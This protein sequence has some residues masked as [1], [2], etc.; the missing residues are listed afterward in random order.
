LEVINLENL[1]RKALL[2]RVGADTKSAGYIGDVLENGDFD[3]APLPDHDDPVWVELS[4]GD[5][6]NSTK[7]KQLKKLNADDLLVFYAGLKCNNVEGAYIIGYYIVDKTFDFSVIFSSDDFEKIFKELLNK[8]KNPHLTENVPEDDI[9][10]IGKNGGLLK[11]AIKIG[12]SIPKG[13]TNRL[14]MD[15]EFHY[16]GYD[17]DLTQSGSAHWLDYDQVWNLLKDKE[18]R[19]P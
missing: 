1:K 18:I 14:M 5:T 11:K 9:V 12:S 10:I 2:I 6:G 7:V 16:L 19:I 13:S 8:Y 3:W 17:G 15:S 4:Y